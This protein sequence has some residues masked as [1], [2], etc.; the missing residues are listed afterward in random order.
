M[1]TVSFGNPT[2][3][4]RRIMLV[5]IRWNTKV[6]RLCLKHAKITRH[7]KNVIGKAMT[8]GEGLVNALRILAQILA[9]VAMSMEAKEEVTHV[10]VERHREASGADLIEEEVGV[11]IAA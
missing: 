4:G 2:P 9:F 1:G 6:L 10:V 11:G 8:T 3:T 7:E 5:K